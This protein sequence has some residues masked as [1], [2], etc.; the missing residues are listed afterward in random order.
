MLVRSSL[1]ELLGD[2][3]EA[4]EFH[5]PVQV[6]VWSAADP[7]VCRNA[8]VCFSGFLESLDTS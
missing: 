5:A 7:V 8:V 2:E 1:W 3:L 4:V 6:Q